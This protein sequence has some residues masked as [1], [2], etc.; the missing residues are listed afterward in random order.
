ML[1]CQ[2]VAHKDGGN[3]PDIPAI[4]RGSQKAHVGSGPC[5]HLG[6]DHP[7]LSATPG[8]GLPLIHWLPQHPALGVA[9]ERCYAG[10]YVGRTYVG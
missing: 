2:H 10:C 5:G 9:E 7:E 3:T 8:A 1:Q 4:C 6:G